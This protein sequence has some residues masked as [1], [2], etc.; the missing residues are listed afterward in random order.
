MTQGSARPLRDN[1]GQRVAFTEPM[2]HL[3]R[4]TEIVRTR[5]YPVAVLALVLCVAGCAGGGG[6][7]SSKVT[8]TVTSSRATPT[9]LAPTPAELAEMIAPVHAGPFPV[10]GGTPLEAT[11][12]P[13]ISSERAR[14]LAL[15]GLRCSLGRGQQFDPADTGCL[16]VDVTFFKRY[17]DAWAARG[18]NGGFVI[19]WG[20]D[21]EMYVVT[22]WGK[23]ALSTTGPFGPTGPGHLFPYTDQSTFQID[24]TTGEGLLSGGIPLPLNTPGLVSYGRPAPKHS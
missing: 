2:L 15:Q 1:G 19:S 9:S 3:R 11:G 8:T 18:Q 5:L 10:A 7:R 4:H 12:G 14:D 17:A 20:P 6:R 21:H 13:Y 24:A 23:L 16:R 22:V